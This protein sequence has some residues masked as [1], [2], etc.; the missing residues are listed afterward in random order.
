MGDLLARLSSEHIVFHSRLVQA[1]IP[2]IPAT[3]R[4]PTTMVQIFGKFRR[5][6]RFVGGSHDAAR[7]F[8]ANIG[9]CRRSAMKLGTGSGRSRP[10]KKAPAAAPR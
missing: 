5:H 8:A 9:K 3:P 7:E 6:R 1:P 2:R 10:S 4:V